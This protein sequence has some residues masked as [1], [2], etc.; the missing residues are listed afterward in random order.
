MSMSEAG[1]SE[2]TDTD[3]FP[4]KRKR[5][6]RLNPPESDSNST[7]LCVVCGDSALG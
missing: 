4:S 5:R 2:K 3:G 7:L 6:S 1:S